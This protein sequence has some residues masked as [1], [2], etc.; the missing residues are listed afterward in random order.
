VADAVDAGKILWGRVTVDGV[1][2]F[3]W[4]AGDEI[5]WAA[6]DEEYIVLAQQITLVRND[7]GSI[8]SRSTMIDNRS[9]NFSEDIDV[10]YGA[11]VQEEQE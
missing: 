6:G 9:V 3:M 8:E 10:L 11:S 4:R 2:R 5:G 1:P 7:I